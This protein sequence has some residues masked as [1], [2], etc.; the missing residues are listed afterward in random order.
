M[1][2]SSEEL[3]AQADNLKDLVS[4]FKIEEEKKEKNIDDFNVKKYQRWDTPN[5]GKKNGKKES[6]QGRKIPAYTDKEKNGIA[7][8]LSGASDEDEFTSY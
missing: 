8:T 1:A 6:P 4:F 2:S 3:A 5:V 7:V